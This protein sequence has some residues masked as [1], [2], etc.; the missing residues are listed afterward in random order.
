MK[1]GI[2]N[3]YLDTLGGGERYTLSF[4]NVLSDLGYGVDLEWKDAG[5]IKALEQ[6][7][8]LKPAD[9]NVVPDIKRG[10]GYDLCFWVSD[11]SIP[12]LKSRKNF[13]H[14]QVPFHDVNGRSLLNKMKLFRIDKV[15]CNSR[16]TKGII[17]KEF[18]VESVVVYPPVAT[19]QFKSKRKKN[20]ILAVGRFSN[21]LQ[22]K[23]QDV[24]VKAFRR[25]FD[26]GNRDWK[27]ILAG[28]TEV[29]DNFT[30]KLSEMSEGY[31][32]HLIKSPDFKTLK[33]SYGSAKI[34]WSASGFGE[35]EI[36][37]PKKVEH[38]GISVVEAMSAGCVPVVFNAG[39]HKEIVDNG[40]NG[41]LWN[42]IAD[43]KETTLSLIHNSAGFRKMS[44]LAKEKSKAYGFEKFKEKVI[45]IVQ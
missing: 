12:A 38:F 24:L 39:G 44:G 34:F 27:L 8:G 32:V 25:I 23:H 22:S 41:Y 15:I 5:I 17:D 33:D 9:I 30:H 28:G 18:G 14:F 40:T 10:D 21:L 20:I 1:V 43:L 36:K 31:P 45:G 11:G 26:E 35:D 7:F 2:Y 6:R 13:L 37:N 3:P 19:E 42:N 29:G 16:F 4:A